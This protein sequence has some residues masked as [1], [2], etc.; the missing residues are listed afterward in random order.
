[1]TDMHRALARVEFD[2]REQLITHLP[3]D[4]ETAFYRSIQLGEKEAALQLFTPLAQEGF[5]RLSDDPLQ[6]LRYHLVITVA[7]ITRACIAGEMAAETAFNLSDLYIRRIDRC[8][9]EEEVHALHRELVEAYADR[10][11]ALSRPKHSRPVRRCIEYIHAHLHEKIAI[12][13]LCTASGLSRSYLSR[14]FHQETGRSPVS[15]I[16][17]RKLEAARQMLEYTGQSVSEIAHV[18][19]FSSESHLISS[20][21]RLSGVTPGEYRRRYQRQL[22]K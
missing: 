2:N 9:S 21:R 14:L 15:F 6:N 16:A 7:F 8:R 11:A 12:S 13:D 4:R 22:A 3:F 1:M 5:G 17:E 20:F 18:L 19:A 10:M